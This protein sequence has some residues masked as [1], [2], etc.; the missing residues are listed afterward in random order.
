VHIVFKDFIRVFCHLMSYRYS[1]KCRACGGNGFIPGHG[2]GS[3]AAEHIKCG[4]G[5]KFSCKL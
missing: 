4:S 1:Q 2:R 3:N 5:R